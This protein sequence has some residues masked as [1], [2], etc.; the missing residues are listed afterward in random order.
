MDIREL[1]DGA[2]SDQF[3][4][5]HLR[6]L[7]IATCDAN[8]VSQAIGHQI[9]APH[10]GYATHIFTRLCAHANALMR[11]VPRSRWTRA[12]SEP[13][14]FGHAAPHCRAIL[15]GFLLFSYLIEE[16]L[17]TSQWSAKLNVMHLKD[18][19]HRIKLMTNIESLDEVAK[20]NEQAEMLKVR[21]LKN[22]WF[23]TLPPETQK[24]CLTGKALTIPSRDDLLKKVN[25]DKE[26]FYFFWDIL[27]QFAH[28][29]PIS[30]YRMEPNGR[31][32]G[33]ENDVDKSYIA[34]AMQLSADA[35]A[36]ATTMLVEAFP[37]TAE[38]RNGIKSKFTLGPRSNR[39]LPAPRRKVNN[40]KHNPL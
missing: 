26:T 36:D 18:C 16:P 35:L 27:S 3:Y 17:S 2:T 9:A 29:L 5:A 30:F 6:G 33:V 20:F 13:W 28:I 37:D 23:L 22:E 34:I 1:L 38:V 31:G 12:D 11:A 32:T 21:L 8:A 10:I 7:D 40:R 24:T 19:T 4:N 14:D 25:W 15:E 39:P